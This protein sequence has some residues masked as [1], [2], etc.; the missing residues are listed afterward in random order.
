MPKQYGYASPVVAASFSSAIVAKVYTSK[1]FT[2]HL[3]SLN[4]VKLNG[5]KGI[6]KPVKSI[7]LSNS[8]KVD[9]G[10]EFSIKKYSVKNVL[11]SASTFAVGATIAI[12]V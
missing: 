12:L 11:A 7:V 10:K 5:G 6:S 4:A 8:V 9:F 1:P 2:T 3:A